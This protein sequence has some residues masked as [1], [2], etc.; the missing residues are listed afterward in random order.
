MDD[1]LNIVDN[2][3]KNVR[4][5]SQLLR[6]TILD[7]FGL[8]A[9]LRWLTENFAERTGI[10]V[11][12]HSDLG[13]RRL[14]DCTETHLFRIAQGTLTNVAR[15]SQATRVTIDLVGKERSVTLSI[16]DNGKGFATAPL[17]GRDRSG[18]VDG[19]V[20]AAR[21]GERSAYRARLERVSRLR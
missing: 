13:G 19:R 17:R 3:V 9:A 10:E 6:P 5:L 20:P 1:C 4:E 2:A 14:A 21:T 7:D 18:L 11:K 8:D 16:Q 15:H 12:Y